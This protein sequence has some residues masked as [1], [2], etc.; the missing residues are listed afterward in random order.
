VSA[1]TKDD[2]GRTAMAKF[3]QDEKGYGSSIA[4]T[5]SDSR[6]RWPQNHV[7]L[8]ETMFFASADGVHG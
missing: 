5:G 4:W 1:L 7:K 3:E 2:D 6:S 8:L